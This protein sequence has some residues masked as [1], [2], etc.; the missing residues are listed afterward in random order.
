MSVIGSDFYFNTI[1]EEDGKRYKLVFNSWNKKVKK[2]HI[3]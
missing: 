3:K 2:V 1:I